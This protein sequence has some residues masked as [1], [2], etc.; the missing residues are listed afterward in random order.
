MKCINNG[1][2]EDCL[3]HEHLKRENSRGTIYMTQSLSTYAAPL[4]LPSLSWPPSAWTAALS[5]PALAAAQLP[6]LAV[7]GSHVT[8]AALDDLSHMISP[9]FLFQKQVF[10]L[11]SHQ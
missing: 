2:E 10:H 7:S 3:S 5:P 1:T 8:T 9:G 6:V 4:G 11:N